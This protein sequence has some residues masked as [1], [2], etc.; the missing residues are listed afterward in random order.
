MRHYIYA[1]PVEGDWLYGGPI[2][3]GENPFH[4]GCMIAIFKDDEWGVP[5]HTRCYNEMER[6]NFSR[7][8][9]R[10]KLGTQTVLAA[11]IG[12]ED[13]NQRDDR[14]KVATLTGT[15]TPWVPG[16]VPTLA[17]S[18]PIIVSDW[19]MDTNLTPGLIPCSGTLDPGQEYQV[20]LPEDNEWT[21]VM[22]R[23]LPL[24]KDHPD[25]PP[26]IQKWMDDLPAASEFGAEGKIKDNWIYWVSGLL[27]LGVIIGILLQIREIFF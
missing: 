8:Y 9:L 10:T 15:G 24:S 17:Q 13:R 6:R 25:P 1:H 20:L 23:D 16:Q 12:A 26:E 21:G 14:P 22:G 4:P 27:S 2:R 11:M 19:G 7:R 5:A 18:P 3:E